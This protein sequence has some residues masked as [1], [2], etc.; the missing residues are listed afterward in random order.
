MSKWQDLRCGV[1]FELLLLAWALVWAAILF[2]SHL[3]SN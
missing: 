1:G 3:L 2:M